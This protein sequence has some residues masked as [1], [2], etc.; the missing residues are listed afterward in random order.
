[1]RVFTHE[2]LI[3][4]VDVRVLGVEV[5]VLGVE[6]G[7]VGRS[8]SRFGA[9]RL[10]DHFSRTELDASFRQLFQELL[11]PAREAGKDVVWVA[12]KTPSNIQAVAALTA[13]FP[14]A[15][16]L[17]VMRDGRD[18]LAS[19]QDVRSRMLAQGDLSR[20]ARTHFSLRRVSARWNAAVAAHLQAAH[21]PELRDRYLL[22]RYEDLVTGPND[23]TRLRDRPLEC[24]REPTS[25]SAA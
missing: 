20:Y 13:L 1:M 4:G 19:H 7:A 14:D 11:R 17:H 9:T 5:L 15:K 24:Q 21:D 10:R 12:E 23:E 2:L 22:V 8:S 25:L 3:L 18:V 6:R 16:F